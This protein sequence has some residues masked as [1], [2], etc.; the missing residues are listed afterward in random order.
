MLSKVG[1]LSGAA[2]FPLIRQPGIE[3]AL[4]PGGK[5]HQQLRQIELWIQVVPAAGG[6]KAGKDGSGTAAARVTD[7]ERIFAVQ[8]DTF[9]F[10]FAHIVIDGNG[11][12]RAEDVEFGPLAQGVV[13][14][15]GHGMLGQQLFFPTQ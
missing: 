6:S 2:E 1:G 9:H 4:R 7:E 5:I 10:P 15:F 12:V 8:Y 3:V 11:P 14:G 13:D